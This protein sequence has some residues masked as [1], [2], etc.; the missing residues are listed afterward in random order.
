MLIALLVGT[1][2]LGKHDTSGTTTTTAPTTTTF[3][4]TETYT[5]PSGA[6]EPT[7]PPRGATVLGLDWGLA[8]GDIPAFWECPPLTP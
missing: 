8:D 6:M 2:E 5:V 4:Q 3:G 7:L 1:F